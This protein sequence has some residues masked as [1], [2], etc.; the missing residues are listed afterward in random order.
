MN[1]GDILIVY[2]DD[3]KNGK[4]YIIY[5]KTFGIT[6]TLWGT[7]IEFL[8]VFIKNTDYKYVLL[9]PVKELSWLKKKKLMDYIT[10]LFI[11]NTSLMLRQ[12]LHFLEF[13]VWL[14]EEVLD[15]KLLENPMFINI[16][17]IMGSDQIQTIS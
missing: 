15:I 4:P 8:D 5:N 11:G 16:D 2:K 7:K 17:N 1:T 14:Y 12:R 10:D 9:T 13:I 3:V 6:S